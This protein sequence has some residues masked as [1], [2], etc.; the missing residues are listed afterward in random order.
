M[1]KK[2]I[3]Q[4][5]AILTAANLI[6][7]LMGFFNRVYMVDAIGV[8][9]MGLYQ[10]VIP[11]YLLSWSIT[12][13]GFSTAVSRITAAEN[14]KHYV[15]RINK[16]VCTSVVICIFISLIVSAAMFFGADIIAAD[17]I[18]ESRTAISIQILAFAVPFMAV[19][20]CMRGYF[21]GLQKHI[22]PAISQVFEQAVRISCITVLAPMFINKGLEYACAAAVIGV[23][24]GEALS[25]ALTAVCYKLTSKYST[26][27]KGDSITFGKAALMI[28]SMALPLSGSRIT[29]SALSAAENILI[30]QKLVLFGMSSTKAMEAF[31]NLTGMALP[32]IQLP[33]SFLVAVSAALIPELSAGQATGHNRHTAYVTSQSL[34]LTI[35]AAIGFTA[36]FMLF[37]DKICMLVYGNRE[38]GK[39][40]IRLAVMCPFMYVHITLAGILNGLGCHSFIF[41]SNIIASVINLIFIYFVMPIYGIDAFIIGMTVG[42]LI[43]TVMGIHEIKKQIPSLVF[44]PKDIFIPLSCAVLSFSAIRFIYSLFDDSSIIPF[45]CLFCIMYTVLLIFSG[46]ISITELKEL[47]YKK[48]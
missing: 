39:L 38:L 27:R 11:I 5:A 47:I 36:V 25:F 7:R 41:V 29:A 23:L 8:E 20:S 16:T 24:T 26:I 44:Y 42:M 12:S 35:A 46:I 34:K 21:Y 37:P 33:S 18:K 15:N 43:T 3:L 45:I 32:L 40:L 31:G 22:Y 10:L 19:G 6:T 28:I 13:S 17:I 9:G 4:G 48:K 2:S 1:S 30:P 14:A